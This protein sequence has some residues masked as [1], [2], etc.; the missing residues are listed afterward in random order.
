[1]S[2]FFGQWLEKRRPD[3]AGEQTRL[4]WH[5]TVQRDQARPRHIALGDEDLLAG[6][7][8]VSQLGEV[9]LGLVNGDSARHGGPEG[10]QWALPLG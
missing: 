1:M 9:G 7:G 6:V 2:L 3:G 10:V 8:A 5:W 4:T